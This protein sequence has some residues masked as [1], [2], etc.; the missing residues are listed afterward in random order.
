M[1]T[2]ADES[3]NSAEEHHWFA[4]HLV[5]RLSLR[6]EFLNLFGFPT[7]LVEFPIGRSYA[8]CL[9][10]CVKEA[11]EGKYLEELAR[12]LFLLIAGW[13]PTQNIYHY[14]GW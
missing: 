6:Q 5:M 10:D 7:R 1:E 13:V 9:L 14:R 4:E 11:S 2:C 3:L 8:R 12:Y